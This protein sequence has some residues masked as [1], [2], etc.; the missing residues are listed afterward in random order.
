MEYR[1]IGTGSAAVEVSA[2]CLGAMNFGTSTPEATAFAILDRFVE[3]GGTFVDTA[4]NYNAWIPGG[5]GRESEDVLGRWIRSRRAHDLVRVATK[6][7][8]GKK[9]PTLPLSGVPPTN[10][11]GLG[12]DVV[13]REAFESMHH[14]GVDRLDVLYGHVDDRATSLDETVGAFGE[15]VSDGVVRVPGI[16]NVTVWRVVEARAAAERLGVAPYAVVQQ[17][18]GY[19]TPSPHPFRSN[20]I[21][22]DLLDYAASTGTEGR[23][24]LTVVAYSPVLKGALSRD[25]RPLSGGTDHVGGR[26]RRQVLR[27][28]AHELGVSPERLALAWLM[29]GDVPVVPLVG[30]STVEQLD[31]ALAAVGLVLDDEVRA[32]LEEA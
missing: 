30:P 8:A 7:G 23:P 26:H 16:S 20:W 13:K 1:T 28:V 17:Q 32:R 25:D 18:G 2:L 12:A 27:Q 19:L 6:C 4:N 3:A 24:P 15:L 9:D 5:H 11:E 29:G 21:T 22:G 10:F 14:L 31:D